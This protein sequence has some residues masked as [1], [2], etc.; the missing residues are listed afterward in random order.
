[1]RP[2]TAGIAVSL[3]IVLLAMAFLIGSRSGK[4]DDAGELGPSG[5]EE[6]S[7]EEFDEGLRLDSLTRNPHVLND[8]ANLRTDSTHPEYFE[9][10]RAGLH[11]GAL[12]RE[13][14]GPRY[15]EFIERIA[16]THATRNIAAGRELRAASFCGFSNWG[17]LQAVLDSPELT[18]V[19][20]KSLLQ[21]LSDLALAAAHDV[22]T[23]AELAWSNP[24]RLERFD[25]SSAHDTSDWVAVN[26]PPN[27]D[28]LLSFV[29]TTRSGDRVFQLHFFSSDFPDLENALQNLQALKDVYWATVRGQ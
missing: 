20:T 19:A 7:A 12:T 2:Q 6:D 29:T 27:K 3:V 4:V 16:V 13:E 28:A 24:Q 17:E 26:Y 18:H 23:Y 1:M 15:D 25:P 22:D 10:N 14:V 21:Q 11:G 8:S 9:L 5:T